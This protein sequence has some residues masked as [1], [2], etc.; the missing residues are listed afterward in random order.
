MIATQL[1]RKF[2]WDKKSSQIDL[3]DL[4]ENLTA[5]EVLEMYSLTYPELTTANIQG[6]KII[7]DHMVFTFSSIIGTKG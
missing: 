2:I 4:G 5:D 6:P 7:D 3:E 1:K